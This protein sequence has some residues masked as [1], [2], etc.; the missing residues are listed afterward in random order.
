MDDPLLA[1][2][3]ARQYQ[4]AARLLRDGSVRT[5]GSAGRTYD[6]SPDGQRFVVL[7]EARDPDAMPPQLIVIQHFDEMLKRLVPAN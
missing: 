2:L 5:V 3:E 4:G 7:K 1:R 6:V